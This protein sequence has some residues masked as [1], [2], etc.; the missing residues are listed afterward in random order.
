M[1]PLTKEQL[2]ACSTITSYGI[3][4]KMLELLADRETLTVA[5]HRAYQ[6]VGFDAIADVLASQLWPES[7]ALIFPDLTLAEI[8]NN[9]LDRWEELS[10]DSFLDEERTRMIPTVRFAIR[11]E[12][13][14]VEDL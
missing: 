4:I 13:S 10:Y 8:V 1:K 14:R 12:E 6:I 2:A 9:T 7:L 5:Q 3:A 11:Q